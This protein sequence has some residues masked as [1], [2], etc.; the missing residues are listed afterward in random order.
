M[1]AEKK[2]IF[3]F[4]LLIILIVSC[5]YSHTQ[6][7]FEKTN[8]NSTNNSLVTKNEKAI[9]NNQEP[10]K[11]STPT[12][13]TSIV[14]NNTITVEETTKETLSTNE[15]NNEVNENIVKEEITPLISID[16]DKYIRE[17]DEKYIQD[18]SI[19]TQ[20]LQIKINEEIAKN[21]IIFKR[22]SDDILRKSEKTVDFIA[23]LLKNE[24]NIKI[25]IAGHTD[26][27]GPDDL[28]KMIS[29]KRAEKIKEL[30]M[31]YGI[32]EDRLVARGYGEDIPF[33]KNNAEGYSLAN[34]R[35]E[36]NIIGE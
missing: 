14:Q 23:R 36:F 5:V 20:E 28:N 4:L 11:E 13:E 17:N 19:K 7:I 25:E 29:I 21:P 6:E 9:N 27:A 24:E 30:I 12:S 15:L 8:N 33:A 34:R 32:L 10:I 3:L 31:S 35:V 22:A 1:N 18:L 26:A 2:V 16:K